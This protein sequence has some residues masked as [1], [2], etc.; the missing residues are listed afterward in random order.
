MFYHVIKV[1]EQTF[2]LWLFEIFFAVVRKIVLQA[3]RFDF[4]N[5]SVNNPVFVSRFGILF[6]C[7]Q[8]TVGILRRWQLLHQKR[9]LFHEHSVL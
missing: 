2:S 8:R 4:K 9:I 6:S 1:N 3:L 5:G 7:K